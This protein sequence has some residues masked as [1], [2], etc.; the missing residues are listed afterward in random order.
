MA[1]TTEGMRWKRTPDGDIKAFFKSYKE[2]IAR[3]KYISIRERLLTATKEELE[4]K[5]NLEVTISI[6]DAILDQLSEIQKTILKRYYVDGME[7]KYIAMDINFNYEYTSSIKVKA[8]QKL[9]ELISEQITSE[10]FK[11][12]YNEGINIGDKVKELIKN[13]EQ[14][15]PVNPETLKYLKNFF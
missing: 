6:T 13:V 4:E 7:I 11:H 5:H 12:L 14:N 15:T 3:V 1:G 8:C 2:A 9:R 10:T